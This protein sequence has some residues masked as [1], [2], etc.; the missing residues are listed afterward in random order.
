LENDGRWKEMGM[1]PREFE[2]SAM[3]PSQMKR[4]LVADEAADQEDADEPKKCCSCLRMGQ[5]EEDALKSKDANFCS[6][7]VIRKDH[8]ML[9]LLD[10]VVTAL[11][12]VSSYFYGLLAAFRYSDFSG[13]YAFYFTFMIS[14]ESIFL[15]HMLLKFITEYQVEGEPKPVRDLSKIATNYL[16]NGLIT[17]IV[18]IFPL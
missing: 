4:H 14:F 15:V 12:L 2:R 1:L 16:H 3:N 13:D 18:C 9:K 5:D 11:C 8:L 7:F 17:D 10:Y 6:K